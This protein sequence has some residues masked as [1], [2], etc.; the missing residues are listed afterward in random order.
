MP[1]TGRPSEPV[2][3]L[4]CAGGFPGRDHRL[5]GRRRVGLTREGPSD[6]STGDETSARTPEGPTCLC[7]LSLATAQLPSRRRSANTC[8]RLVLASTLRTPR[9]RSGSSWPATFPPA[10]PSLVAAADR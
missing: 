6:T 8:P 10:V 3:G 4:G 9:T 5:M 7:T 2:E 1:P